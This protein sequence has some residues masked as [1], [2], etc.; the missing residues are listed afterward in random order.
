VP[1][2]HVR[3][4]VGQERYALAVKYVCEVLE[5]G[6]LTAVPGASESMLGLRNL[7]GEILPVFDLARLLSIQREGPLSRLIVT[8]HSSRRAAF[9]VDDVL[10]VGEISGALEDS[11][12]AFL[13]AST[14][15]DGQL[16]G[17][18]A[19][20]SLIDMVCQATEQ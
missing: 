20:G 10:D 3:V 15:I 6:A 14:V 4:R 13:K 8:E 11:E 2:V 1:D 5:L 16:V 19:V 12:L 18:L 7:N 17:V 9:A